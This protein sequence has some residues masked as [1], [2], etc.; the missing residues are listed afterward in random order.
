[1]PIRRDPAYPH[2]VPTREKVTAALLAHSRRARDHVDRHYQEPLD[3]DELAAKI[4]K[5]REGWA[6]L[7]VMMLFMVAGCAVAW[8]RP[9]PRR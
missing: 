7:T 3:L 2:G 4:G 9:S 8:S 5:E 1:M 6:L